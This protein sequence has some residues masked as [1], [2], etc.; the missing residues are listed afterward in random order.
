M[1]RVE[2]RRG[3]D[4]GG[5]ASATRESVSYLNV[6]A[7]LVLMQFSPV[8]R[9]ERDKRAWWRAELGVPVSLDAGEVVRDGL[10]ENISVGGLFVATAHCASVGDRVKLRFGLPGRRRPLA[11]EGE[12]RWLRGDSRPRGRSGR[13]GM[14]LEFVRL[15]AEVTAT[16]AAFLRSRSRPRPPGR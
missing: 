14:G 13:S 11:A 2:N 1:G 7:D 8:A 12:V 15:S 10:A 9:A 16:I 3:S 6:D 5:Q 4:K